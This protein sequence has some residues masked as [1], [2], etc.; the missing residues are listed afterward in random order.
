MIT[1]PDEV[2]VTGRSDTIQPRARGFS[3]RREDDR[4]V[5]VPV[6]ELIKTGLMAAGGIAVF[7]ACF[8]LFAWMVVDAGRANKRRATLAQAHLDAHAGGLRAGELAYEQKNPER[9]VFSGALEGLSTTFE[10]EGVLERGWLGVRLTLRIV[11]PSGLR[12][13]HYISL[14]HDLHDDPALDLA[15]ARARAKDQGVSRVDTSAIDDAT[16]GQIVSF[17]NT[18]GGHLAL[19][20]EALEWRERLQADAPPLP[21]PALDAQARTRAAAAIVKRLR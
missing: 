7:V 20:P 4:G 14:S 17:L 15:S 12:V 2:K 16:M 21:T 6:S 13:P 3:C 18:F 10:I 8:G 11:P 1:R 5:E 19:T 9:H